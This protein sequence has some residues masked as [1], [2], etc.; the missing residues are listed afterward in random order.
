MIHSRNKIGRNDPCW[1]GSEKKYKNCHLEFDEH[2]K[3][4]A[5]EGEI[6]PSH[7]LLK[8]HADIEGIKQS[9]KVN[10][11]ALDYVQENI[12]EGIS[13]YEI[14]KWV[15]DYTFDHGARP[16]PL[17]Y[18][19]FPNSCCTS[20][21]DV[22]CHGIPDKGEI[23]K[24]GDIINVD[25]STEL[26]GYY[27]DSSRMFVIGDVD[28]QTS[29]LVEVV[30]KSINVGL[31]VVKPYFHL[32]DIAK[33]IEQYVESF[34]FSVV[35]EYGGHGIGKEFHE[36][37]WVSHTVHAGENMIMPPGMCFTIEPMI[38]AGKH[39]IKGPE[40]N[41]WTIRT[42]DSSNSAQCEIQVVITDDGYEIVSY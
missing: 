15:H 36:E 17:G 35:R 30:R 32:R 27:S 25:C 10:I 20:I 41:G 34:G 5:N 2:L 26:D 40:S 33:A 18:E 12:K 8:T 21:N 42:K 38:N 37:P 4:L 31:G 1:C 6:V 19:G 3:Q 11:G 13:T 23:L 9:A 24:N 7:H 39:K 16:A 29:K 28:Q 14:D 22:V